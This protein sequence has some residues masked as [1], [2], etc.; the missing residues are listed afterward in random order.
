MIVIKQTLQNSLTPNPN[1]M[2]KFLEKFPGGR[3]RDELLTLEMRGLKF[4]DIY[5]KSV[6]FSPLNTER[7]LNQS[8]HNFYA[9]IDCAIAMS[10]E[11]NLEYAYNAVSNLRN[12]G[13]VDEHLQLIDFF[14]P[15][16]TRLLEWGYSDYDL[17]G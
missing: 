14:M 13:T 2:M 4:I 3:E 16:Y 6:G 10:D 8:P 12:G 15:V 17:V 5:L 11:F 1:L 7:K 9:T